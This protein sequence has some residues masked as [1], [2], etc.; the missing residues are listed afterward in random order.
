MTLTL[1]QTSR[2]ALVATALAASSLA[3]PHLAYAQATAPA[4]DDAMPDAT[5]DNGSTADMSTMTGSGEN[6]GSAAQSGGSADTALTYERV[7]IDLQS[8]RDFTELLDGMNAD[9]SVTVTGL[10]ALEQVG[11]GAVSTAEDG[12]PPMTG[13]QTTNDTTGTAMAPSSDMAGALGGGATDA[14]DGIATGLSTGGGTQTATISE[15]TPGDI[16]TALAQAQDTLSAL[17]MALSG[18]DA[19]TEALESA[20]YTADD[21]IALHRDGADLT[22]IVDDRN[23]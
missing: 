9:T 19:V 15:G 1:S 8:G 7:V 16:D 3:V 6:T 10:S 14:P 20:D 21:V 5:D 2:A 4:T 12:T 23:D 22:I 11:G 17:R 13:G 18:Q